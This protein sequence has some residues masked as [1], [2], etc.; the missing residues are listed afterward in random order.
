[1]AVVGILSTMRVFGLCGLQKDSAV[2]EWCVW[3]VS[4]GCALELLIVA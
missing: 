1:M 2:V 4:D 3:L